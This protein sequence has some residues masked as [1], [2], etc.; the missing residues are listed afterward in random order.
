MY[1]MWGARLI[2]SWSLIAEWICASPLLE[3]FINYNTFIA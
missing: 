2:N 1:V 3:T